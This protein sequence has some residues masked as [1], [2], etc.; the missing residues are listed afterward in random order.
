ME[1]CVSE[2]LHPAAPHHLPSFITAPGETDA[3]M[4]VVGIILI[5]SVVGVGNLYL[6]LHTLPERQAHKS[7]KL[8]F[9]IVAVLCLLAL[10]THNH[11][12]WVIGLFLGMID[13]PDFGT[14]LRRIA[15]SVEKMAGVLPE[16]DPSE[17]PIETAGHAAGTNGG[18]AKSEADGHA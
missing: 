14:P 13:L 8:Q 16:P 4:I 5:V 3:L 12:F 11:L 9:E 6:H 2:S 1:S 18:A 15:G 7:Q 10:F 17:P